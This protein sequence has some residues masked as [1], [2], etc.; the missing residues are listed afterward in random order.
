MSRLRH[1]LALALTVLLLS[2]CPSKPVLELHSARLQSA[3][4]QGIGFQI[5][6]RVN[7]DNAFDVKIRNVRASV[8]IAGRYPLPQLQYNPDQWLGAGQTT[9]VRVPMVVPWNLVTPLMATTAGSTQ[10]SYHVRG[11]ADVTA[12]RLLGIEKNDY[13]IDEEG[14]VSRAELVV[15]AARG[16]FTAPR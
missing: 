4:P 11:L 12:V 10:I 7:N 2:A 13:P 15:A 3:S 16:V 1:A 14:T 9:I 5:E 6:L 8:I